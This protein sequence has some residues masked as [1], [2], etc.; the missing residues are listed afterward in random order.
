[1]DER[2]ARALQAERFA[3]GADLFGQGKYGLAKRVLS[4]AQS[5]PDNLVAHRAAVYLDICRQKRTSK[6]VALTS[7]EDYYNYA[8]ELVNDRKL[9]E[10]LRMV[11]RGLSIEPDDADLHYLKAVVNALAGKVR[12]AVQPMK[13]AIALDPDIR[14]VAMQDPDLKAIIHKAPLAKLF[15]GG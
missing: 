2:A 6:R 4:R 1:M 3:E 10:A 5:G 9:D 14:V 12:S 11:R 15:S 8:V 13:R 7:A